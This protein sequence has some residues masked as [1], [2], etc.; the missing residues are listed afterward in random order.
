MKP[1]KKHQFTGIYCI[2]N[3]VNNKVYIGKSQNIYKRIHQHI[4]DLNNHDKR[5]MENNYLVN[6]WNK[7][8][9]D[10]FEYI[11]L[12]K[13]ID[14]ITTAQRELYWMKVF[15]SLNKEK[16]YNLR[17][18]SDSKM[19]CNIETKLKISKRVKKEWELGLRNNHGEKLSNN[20]KTTPDRNNK[21]SQ[22]M[23]KN[24]TK[25]F[26]K[27]DNEFLTYKELCIRGYKSAIS[28]FHKKK[29]SIIKLKGKLIEKV[30]IDDIVRSS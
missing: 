14:E 24:L 30:K 16:G 19:I 13:T 25:Y 7:Y 2:R 1:N 21:Q 27:I 11:V 28:E 5:K 8:G 23:I 18:D 17:S 3:L 6:S 12:E 4:Y 15:D 20:W 22:I 29:S 26:Y 10:S 9:K